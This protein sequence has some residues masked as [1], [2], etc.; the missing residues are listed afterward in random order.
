[1][2]D[3]PRVALLIETSNS[4]A[5][6]LLRG[7]HR[8]LRQHRPWTID[9]PEQ[10]RG[11]PP[12]LHLAQWRGDGIIARIENPRIAAAVRQAGLPTIDVSA[13]RLLPD[14]P[15]VETDNEAI[16]RLAVGHLIAAGFK[17]FAFCGDDRFAWSRVRRAWFERI[18]TEAGFPT[19]SYPRAAS[20]RTPSWEQ[21]RASLAEWLA[22]LPKPVGIMACYDQ[23]GWQVLEICRDIG[24]GVPDQVAV[25]GVDNDELLCELAQPSLS[26][27]IP[28]TD[29]TGYTAAELL[30]Q[31]MAG[32]RVAAKEHLIGPLGIAARQST[33]LLAGADADVARAVRFI[34]DHACDG[35]KV[36]A[37]VDELAM[38]RR[39]LEHRFRRLLGHTPHD[40]ILRVQIER[41]SRLLA[42]TDLPLAVIADRTGFKHAEYM[43]VAFKRQT[44]LSPKGFRDGRRETKK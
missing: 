20:R 19:S 22:G 43:S 40:E 33:D 42:E 12:P 35:I 26:S 24:L 27:V 8:Y 34:R 5:R 36:Q 38:S 13:A 9:L 32:R 16:V 21:D 29:Q 39:V 10:G 28:D 6:G 25:I 37:V 3:R 17:Q 31:M 1:M 2:P 7:I 41:V 44:G 4:Y 14:L 18:V 30:G 23:R 11:A 15:V